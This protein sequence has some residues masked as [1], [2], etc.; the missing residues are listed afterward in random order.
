MRMGWRRPLEKREEIRLKLSGFKSFV[1]PS[2]LRRALRSAAADRDGAGF[3]ETLE[4]LVAALRDGHG[5]V[6]SM[7]TPDR[8]RPLDE[9]L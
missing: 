9:R 2:E 1:E 8:R 4:E 5:V 7:L 3:V 6:V